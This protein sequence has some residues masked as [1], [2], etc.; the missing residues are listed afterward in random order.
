[1]QSKLHTNKMEYMRCYARKSLSI[2]Q[3]EARIDELHY[4]VE[5]QNVP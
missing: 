4:K 3:V 5:A 2:S 1:M